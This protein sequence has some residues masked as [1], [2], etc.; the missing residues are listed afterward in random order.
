MAGKKLEYQVDVDASDAVSE[1]KKVGDAGEKAGK[2]LADGFKDVGS[3]SEAA[4]DK[5][6]GN[7]KQVTEESKRTIETVG[8][9]GDKFGEGFDPQATA[10]LVNSLRQAG[11][12]FDTIEARAD[13]L[14]D[15]MR[16]IDSIRIEGPG[17]GLR[18]MSSGMDAVRG[19]ARGVGDELGHVRSESDQSRSVLANMAGNTAQ[20]LG[21]LGGVVGSLGVGI[22]QLAEYAVDGNIA[23][24]NLA[25]TAGPLAAV[26]AA[27]FLIQDAF[28]NMAETKAFQT[29]AVEDYAGAIDE[30]GD[31][32]QAVI[33]IA[34]D[35]LSGRIRDESILGGL[36]DKEKTVDLIKLLD[37][38]G[39]TLSDVNDAIRSGAH[40]RTEFSDWINGSTPE[41]IAFRAAFDDL[42]NSG[43]RYTPV[44]EAI[45]SNTIAYTTATEDAAAKTRVMASSVESVNEQLRLMRIDE[46][47]LA[48]LTEGAIKFGDVMVDP[49]ALWK[50][51]VVDLRDGNVDMLASAMAIDAFAAAMHLTV[52]EV[53]A[54]AI[55]QGKGTKAA[56]DYQ[57]AVEA[58]G[59]AFQKTSE[60][61]GAAAKALFDMNRALRLAGL[62]WDE[63]AA[64]ATSFAAGLD[65]INAASEVGF[66]QKIIDA[67]DA[68]DSFGE[69]LDTARQNG[70]DFANTDFIPDTWAEVRDM[71]KDVAPLVDA[72]AT[73]RDQI[74]T[75]LTDAFNVG[76]LPAFNE[77]LAN[78]RRAV[79]NELRDAGIEGGEEFRQAMKALGLDDETINI[80]L[81]VQGEEEARQK[82]DTIL[83]AVNDIP[84]DILLQI[85]ATAMIDPEQALA[86]LINYVENVLH[87]DVPAT[88]EPTVDPPA[89]NR[90]DQMLDALAAPRPTEVQPTVPAAEAN[91]TKKTLGGLAE[92]RTV[93]YTTE[94]P[95]ADATNTDLD[96]VGKGLWSSLWGS[97]GRV[98]SYRTE[99]PGASNLNRVLDA[100]AHPR[101]AQINLD[102]NPDVFDLNHAID[103]ASR[104]RT[105]HITLVSHAAGATSGGTAGGQSVGTL[106]AGPTVSAFATEDVGVTPFAAPAVSSF[107]APVSVAAAAPSSTTV[108]NH[109]T[110]SAAVIGSRFDVQRAVT[111]ALRSAQRLNGAR[112]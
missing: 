15:T 5:V 66:S 77:H 86:D 64:R 105:T 96:N 58:T 83:G 27:G 54:L 63:A 80:L 52:P 75:E 42:A 9:I 68:V 56:N 38:A 62:N 7:L 44:M 21:Q 26:A 97:G 16:Q 49:A 14:A 71:D 30:V 6:I 82:I 92:P 108:H 40:D 60:D 101:T 109:V 8:K 67:S 32:M 99:A 79:T 4:F 48:V 35:G 78:I 12:E 87:V 61:G 84:P 70:V 103:Y 85:Q 104:N 18:D 37:E 55:E 43:E 3:K 110:I 11:V 39:L 17:A 1:L 51:L 90:T 107:A 69:A 41:A 22:G 88:L 24:A 28:K 2:Q 25:K 112:V 59:A 98:A 57:V 89:S 33:D 91:A 13:E 65:A 45:L 93:T 53:E 34:E 36:L 10:K 73:M 72:F 100:I 106:S 23:L 94:A 46:N 47:P 76:G 95:N 29:K 31:S 102:T 19:S 20:D 50:Q 111:K 81:Q 74:Q